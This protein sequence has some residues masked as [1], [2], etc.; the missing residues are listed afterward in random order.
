MES[1]PCAPEAESCS[2]NVSKGYQ[3]K[4]NQWQQCVSI[5]E[6]TIGDDDGIMNSGTHSDTF[7]KHWPQVGTQ[8]RSMSCFDES[9]VL[10]SLSF[11]EDKQLPTNT[12]ACIIAQDCVVSDW[13]D[14]EFTQ[15]GCVSAGGKVSVTELFFFFLFLILNFHNKIKIN[16]RVLWWNSR[17]Q[18]EYFKISFSHWRSKRF[19]DFSPK[20]RIEY[21]KYF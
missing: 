18:L 4:V 14:W 3:L 11:C 6:H 12:R 13:T 16:G 2:N 5:S 8:K 15:G 9:G 19:Y 10:V 20:T 7:Y 1:R 17:D 21:Y